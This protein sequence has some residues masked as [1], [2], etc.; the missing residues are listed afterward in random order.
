[1]Q[2]RSP[3]LLPGSLGLA[4]GALLALGCGPVDPSQSTPP[5]QAPT[6]REEHIDACA[7]GNIAAQLAMVD[8]LNTEF[9]E[10][11][12]CGALANFY[13]FAAVELLVN[14]STDKPTSPSGF[15]FQG[16]GLYLAGGVMG[17]QARLGRDTSF[18]KAGDDVPFDLFDTTEYFESIE[19]D[20]NV[21]VG[22]SLDTGGGVE[23]HASGSITVKS[24]KNPGSALE[25]F[26]IDPTKP[27]ATYDVQDLAEA[28]GK[29]VTFGIE[30]K[31]GEV[32]NLHGVAYTLTVPPEN[33]LDIYNGGPLQFEVTSIEAVDEKQT[34]SL[35]TW[36][37]DYVAGHGG[38]L[39]GTI[40]M[41]VDGDFTYY[42]KYEYLKQ[43]E[44][45]IY[46]TCD[47]P[48]P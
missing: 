17:L 43:F 34:A 36:D 19:L 1:M 41:R 4:L 2:H 3:L 48:A 14:L 21:K 18:G 23:S 25:L 30:I 28:M 11:P 13:V 45:N 44:P 22:V 46:I 27:G 9:H 6:V 20:A 24:I 26:G 16:S 15:S 33:L 29:S 42:V 37:I 5:P 10:M 8:K 35:E 32:V 7:K 39:D 47:P 12:T 40:V 38:Y 31:Q